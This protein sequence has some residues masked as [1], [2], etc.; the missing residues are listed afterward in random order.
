MKFPLRPLLVSLPF[1]PLPFAAAACAAPGD[2]GEDKREHNDAEADRVLNTLYQR[3]PGARAQ[4]AS[5]A[6]YA[7]FSNLSVDV[8]LIGGGGGYGVAV[9]RSPGGE[10]TYMRMGEGSVGFGLGVKDFR[11]VFIFETEERYRR[12]VEDGWDVGADAEAT[13]K[14]KG[15][16]GEVNATASFVDGVAVYQLTETG[17]ALRASVAG[18]RYWPYEALNADG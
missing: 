18:T 13:A 2:T 15:S 4:I 3:A 8:L 9:D 12:F 5:S 7:V 6:G 17:L 11:A 1:L 16:G 14:A 10:R